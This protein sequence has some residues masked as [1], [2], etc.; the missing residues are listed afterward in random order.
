MTSN[1]PRRVSR[2]PSRRKVWIDPARIGAS[3]AEHRRELLLGQRNDRVAGALHRRDDPLRGALLD[4]VGR[5]AGCRLHHLRQ[6]AIRIAGE[7]AAQRRRLALRC[8]QQIEAKLRERPAELHDHAR[9]GRQV[10]A[11]DDAA[12][13]A[14]TADQHGLDIAAVLARHQIG[15]KA[16]P[17]RKIDRADMIARIVKQMPRRKIRHFQRRCDQGV[18]GR[19]QC[20]QQIVLRPIGYGVAPQ[21]SFYPKSPS[22]LLLHVA[23]AEPA[24]MFTTAQT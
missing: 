6:H 18:I 2:T 22:L 1:E 23:N 8:F 10:A 13:R 20:T 5:V 21:I 14:F 19:A 24:C 4:R 12:D 17:A 11:A 9:I 16:R 15:N 3:D 7:H